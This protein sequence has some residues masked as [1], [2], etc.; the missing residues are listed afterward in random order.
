MRHR[1]IALFLT[2]AAPAA[3]QVDVVAIGMACP[4]PKLGEVRD[5]PGTELGQVVIG[6][7]RT[8]GIPGTTVPIVPGLS[9]GFSVA[10]KADTPLDVTLVT[11]HPP[12]GPKRLTVQSFD[13]DFVPGETRS[14]FYM[15]EYD[16]EMLPGPWT[17]A[18]EAEGATLASVDFTVTETPDPRVDAICGPAQIS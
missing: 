11:R 17:L 7:D 18:I 1:L 6:T 10:L 12:M 4:A 2:C 8:I 16:Y 13:W 14:H 15:F 5:A 3:A 9:F